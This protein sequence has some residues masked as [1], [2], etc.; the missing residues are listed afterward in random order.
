MNMYNVK[1]Q[2]NETIYFLLLNAEVKSMSILSV[3]EHTSIKLVYLN[4][5]LILS[6][7]TGKSLL[8]T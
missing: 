5:A 6:H 4:S 8:L 7:V 2:V 3:C 1:I